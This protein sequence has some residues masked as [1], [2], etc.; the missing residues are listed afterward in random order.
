MLK[1]HPAFKKL[2][3]FVGKKNNTVRT[4]KHQ[5]ATSGTVV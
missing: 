5:D 4:I 1:I 3:K 2:G